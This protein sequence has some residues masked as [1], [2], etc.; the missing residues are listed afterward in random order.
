VQLALFVYREERNNLLTPIFIEL[1]E[2][3]E[4]WDLAWSHFFLECGHFLIERFLV[5]FNVCLLGEGRKCLKKVFFA[6]FYFT[7]IFV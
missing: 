4:L 7:N 3:V 2:G 1:C 5:H 6:F